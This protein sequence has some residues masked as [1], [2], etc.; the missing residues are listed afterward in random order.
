MNN[1][2]LHK[3]GKEP[4][5]SLDET[6]AVPVQHSNGEAKDMSHVEDY[7]NGLSDEEAAYAH[8]HLSKRLNK[9]GEGE[10]DTTNTPEVSME[11]F[12]KAM[13]KGEQ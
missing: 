7:V 5:P 12:D 9:G 8:K 2:P 10:A 13:G 1:K 11:D 4:L 6:K 3:S